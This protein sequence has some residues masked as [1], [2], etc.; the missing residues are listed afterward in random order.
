MNDIEHQEHEVE[1][2]LTAKESI[3]MLNNHKDKY[4][5]AGSADEIYMALVDYAADRHGSWN[6]DH[7]S[8]KKCGE[9]YY[10]ITWEQGVNLITVTMT[11]WDRSY[12]V[13]IQ[14]DFNEDGLEREQ[15]AMQ[16]NDN[17]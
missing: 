16:P 4:L 17:W 8:P 6:E 14:F 5:S 1:Q 2:P 3:Q 11:Q 13:E 12:K 10:S 15:E 9:N 7:T